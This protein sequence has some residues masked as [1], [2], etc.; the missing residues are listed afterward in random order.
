MS[1]LDIFTFF[2]AGMLSVSLVVLG[3]VYIWVQDDLAIGV[4]LI[5]LGIEKAQWLWLWLRYG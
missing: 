3:I 1:K 4:L 2:L 5:V